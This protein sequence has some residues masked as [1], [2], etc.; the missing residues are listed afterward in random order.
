MSLSVSTAKKRNWWDTCP[1]IVSWKTRQLIAH[2]YGKDI[3]TA[4]KRSNETGVGEC[5]GITVTRIGRYV[6]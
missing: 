6:V 3:I 2:G 1:I 5:N 4:V